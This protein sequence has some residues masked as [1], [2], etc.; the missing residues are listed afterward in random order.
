M[1]TSQETPPGLHR[2]EQVMG[3]PIGIDVRDTHVDPVSLD[4]AFHWFRSVD[5]TFSTYRPDSDISRL[6]RREI[7]LDEAHPDV[8]RVLRRCAQ[9]TDQTNGYFDIRAT[10]LPASARTWDADRF[11]DAVD[12][13]G[14]VKGWSV[15][16]AAR[17]LDLA[18]ASNYS[19]NAGGDIRV[20]G[21]PDGEAHVWR[22]GI[23]HP[24]ITDKVAAVVAAR[25]TAIATSG[26]YARG[27][28]IVDPHTG[29]PP[30]GVLS[31]TIVG[32]DLATADAFA[33]AAFAMGLAG[34]EWTAR[35][36][37]YE[38]MTILEDERVLSTQNF[39]RG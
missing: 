36:K 19:I 29:L 13:S 16:R 24:Y 38:A 5:S 31:V 37:D 21:R 33:T 18:G 39:P 23:Q 8:R 17:I 7:T 32:P 28:H 14:L 30:T 6:N 25:D 12:P 11:P 20:K 27:Q 35:L 4:R 2:V 26:T 9:L 1:T 34:P 10:Y 3:M 22:I 15:E